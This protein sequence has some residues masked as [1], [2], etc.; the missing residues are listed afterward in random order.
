MNVYEE[1]IPYLL[2]WYRYNARVLPWREDP[3]AYHVW[4]SEIM[5]QQTR[6]EAVRAY[7][8]R[9]LEEL[10][11]VKALSECP[12]DRLMK[13]WEGL[14]Y[15]S[16]ARNLK[17]AAQAVCEQYGGTLPDTVTELRKLPGIGDY[18]AGAIA[19]IAFHKPEPAV[20]G[21]VLRVLSRLSGSRACIALPEV[22]KEMA[23]ELRKVMPAERSGELNQAIMDIGATVC[24]PNGSP[25][26]EECPLM[27]LCTAFRE[28]TTSEIP[29]KE[30]KKER[31]IEE[32]TVFLIECEG[33]VLLHRR[34]EKGLLAGLF[35]YPNV[36]G[37][38]S[39]K[40]AE[41]AV[42]E[43]FSETEYGTPFTVRSIKKADNAK[44]IFSH[45]E[46]HMTAYLVK[47]EKGNASLPDDYVWAGPEDLRTR[48]SLPT[49]FAKWDAR[50]KAKKG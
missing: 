33:A 38:L 47:A 6:V 41:A 21:N 9:F 35:E 45:I 2:H 37:K 22:K 46:W 13:L 4:I 25:H 34:P 40:K 48:Y 36:L 14:G 17:K 39:V 10:P 49:A 50:G 23:A 32:R 20:D 8:T 26:C 29:V 28:G 42:S 19:S 16:R 30:E 1:M 11:D 31:R 18:T 7:Y 24:V 5:L 3:S 12:D 44:H 27:H 15:Y 43:L